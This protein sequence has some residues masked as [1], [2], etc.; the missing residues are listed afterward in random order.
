MQEEQS[1]FPYYGLSLREIL[2]ESWG[3]IY[4]VKWSILSAT[5]VAGILSSI[6]FLFGYGINFFLGEWGRN[7]YIIYAL[8]YILGIFAYPF[9]AGVIMLG[10]R[11]AVNEPVHFSMTFNYYTTPLLILSA[12]FSVIS[13]MIFALLL[14]WGVDHFIA[15]AS[16]LLLLPLFAFTVPLVIEKGMKP[17]EAVYTF[18]KIFRRNWAIIIITY[19]VLFC[20]NLFGNFVLIGGIWTVPLLFVANGVLY[21][22]LAWDESKEEVIKG[23]GGG[24]IRISMPTALQPGRKP[25][26]EGSGFQNLFAVLMIFLLLTSVGVR[27]YAIYQADK[28]YPPDN[29]ASNGKNVC[30]HFNNTLFLLT[31]DGQMQQRLEL[32]D[33]GINREP[34]DI[35]LLEDNSILIGDLDNGVILRCDIA[36][37]SC[38]KIGPAGGYV[39]ND[40]FKFLVDEKRNLLYI[41]DTNNH[42]LLVQD[43][44]GNY[45]NEVE[46]DSNIDYPNDMALDKKGLLWL[47]NTLHSRILSFEVKG[48]TVVETG[49]AIKL[50]LLHTSIT[51]MTQTFLGE[52][53]PREAIAEL[54]DLKDD[55]EK[56]KKAAKKLK[57]VLLHTRPL[58]L[59]WGPDDN[60]WVAASDPY[61]TTAGVQVFNSE[62]KQ[63]KRINLEKKAIPVDIIRVGEKILVADTG[64]FRVYSLL[65]G[66]E[67]EFDFGD[68][69]FQYEL[70]QVHGQLKM[71]ESMKKWAGR[72]LWLLAIGVIILVIIIVREKRLNIGK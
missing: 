56:M 62:G 38:R 64:L 72:S 50:D 33:L 41:A 68:E 18:S 16:N 49:N 36:N 69:P 37:M 39:I 40:N 46:S 55:P 32:A 11:R 10:I 7:L 28:I 61:V 2:A 4:G 54:Q 14:F 31:P 1:H 6:I 9:L 15:T 23:G 25:A 65:P 35:E 43:M 51:E 59:A 8:Q 21:R 30:V 5:I 22:N 20:I 70:S 24:D 53:D 27:L 13:Y 71:Y 12:I 44:E 57:E 47:S 34:A 3:R 42:R 66:S 29:V 67:Y 26:L 45:L 17:F 60:I 63:I 58:A 52:K 19:L 48:N